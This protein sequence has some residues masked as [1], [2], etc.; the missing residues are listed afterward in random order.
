M[1]ACYHTLHFL[2]E[3]GTEVSKRN[4]PPLLMSHGGETRLPRC[5]SPMLVSRPAGDETVTRH[6]RVWAQEK[7]W[8]HSKARSLFKRSLSVCNPRLCPGILMWAFSCPW[9][10]ALLGPG[11]S[12]GCH[13]AS[14]GAPW[15]SWSQPRF[16][17]CFPNGFYPKLW[18]NNVSKAK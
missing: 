10:P 5:D 4:A 15:W 2:L 1:A 9:K 14:S 17:F 18:E 11:T 13:Q 3:Q 16:P 7:K 6:V 12:L 8:E